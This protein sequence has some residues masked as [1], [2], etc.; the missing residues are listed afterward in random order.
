MYEATIKRLQYRAL[1]IENYFNECIYSL[2]YSDY[3]GKVPKL[4][5]ERESFEK[6]LLFLIK[7][8]IAHRYDEKQKYFRRAI[9]FQRSNSGPYSDRYE[10]VART[11]LGVGFYLVYNDSDELSTMYLDFIK[12]GINRNSRLFWGRIKSIQPLVE[13][14]FIMM[15]LWLNQEKLWHRLEVD[16]QDSFLQYIKDCTK[17]YFLMNNWQWFKVFHFLFLEEFGKYNY[18]D[19]IRHVIEEINS[20][21]QGDGWYNDGKYTGE[22][23]YDGY[24]SFIF[25]YY[26]LSFCYFAGNKYDDIKAVLKQRFDIF[27]KSYMLCFGDKN[28]HLTWGRSILYKFATLACFG[29]AVALNLLSKDEMLAIKRATI[30]IINTFFEEGILDLKGLLTMGFTKPVKRVLE[31]YSGDA[32]IYLVLLAFFFLV[33]DKK[34]EFWIL[35]SSSGEKHKKKDA[36]IKALNLYI[37][38]DNNHRFLLNSGMNSNQ[39]HVYDKY[40]RF[41]YSN[42]FHRTFD[43]KYADNLFLFHYQGK[44][45]SRDTIIEKSCSK[46]NI[47]YMKWG[48]SE[49]IG[50]E[51]YT[52]MLPL[53]DGYI[54]I[55]EFVVPERINFTFCGF[56]MERGEIAIRKGRGF[57]ELR[58]NHLISKLTVI[59]PSVGKLDYKCLRGMSVL[60]GEK[61]AVPYFRSEIVP[62]EAKVVLCVQGG[63]KY[64]IHTPE[65]ALHDNRANII[66]AINKKELKLEKSENF[67]RLM[68]V[69]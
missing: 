23:R 30:N 43:S 34:H 44:Y 39:Y 53:E 18:E 45:L 6:L 51:G 52:T 61:S 40:N 62:H 13:N 68:K 22:F 48:I 56:N 20:Y 32:S 14:T 16:V 10:L 11:F 66:D 31:G 33:L 42:I 65:I 59:R 12:T 21:Y 7:N 50:F 17:K 19:K 57:I 55:N 3:K 27:K 58:S 54:I 35:N 60:N 41:A 15:G 9:P 24:N 47:M 37:R 36:F 26:G 46:H 28:L 5:D 38:N 29:P 1:I 67:Y 25:H 4:N 2:T 8:V 69:I 49:M 64:N 63:K